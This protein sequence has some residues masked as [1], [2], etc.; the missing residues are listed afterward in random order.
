MH[1]GLGARQ[2]QQ[3]TTIWKN[4]VAIS[5]A[6]F[7]FS[8]GIWCV[9]IWFFTC[10]IFWS[11]LLNKWSEAAIHNAGWYMKN[12]SFVKLQDGPFDHSPRKIPVEDS[13]LIIL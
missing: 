13:F 6:C 12:S 9:I 1:S 2:V 7:N 10:L 8:F 3:A 4:K 11:Y 5:Q